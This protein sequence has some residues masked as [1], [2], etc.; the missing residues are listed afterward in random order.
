MAN[1]KEEKTNKLLI[2][3]GVVF[4]IAAVLLMIVAGVFLLKDQ[5]GSGGEPTAVPPTPELATP[6]PIPPADT[7]T[8]LPLPTNTPQV[9]QPIQPTNPLVNTTWTL[10]NF[11]DPTQGLVPG[12]IITAE[13]GPDTI[14]GSAGCN[15][16]NGGYTIS[17]S[18]LSVGALTST[19]QACDELVMQQEQ[20]YLT[21]LEDARTYLTVGKLLYVSY[22]SSFGPG[23]LV[24]GPPGTPPNY[25]IPPETGPTTRTET[26]SGNIGPGEV[27]QSFINA[28]AGETLAISITSANN[29]AVFSVSGQ[30]DHVIYAREVG[31]WSATLTVTQDYLVTVTSTAA[32]GA[33]AVSYEMIVSLTSGG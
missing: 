27:R 4:I 22:V 16:Y 33:E 6:T 9:E 17:G 30:S 8:P 1:D 19:R 29:T 15:D 14:T 7:P 5:Q 26:I 12:T 2:G 23:T 28:E 31:N 21:A 11:G 25:V 32:E 18:N 13:F 24:Y 10:I 3:L 20:N